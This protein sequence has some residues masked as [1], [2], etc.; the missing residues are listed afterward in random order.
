M[1]SRKQQRTTGFVANRVAEILENSTIDQWR[2]VEG[3]LNLVD[4]GSRGMT[5]EALKESGWL[6]EPV[7]LSMTEVAWPKVPE[8]LQFSVQ[9]EPEPFMEAVVMEPPFQ[10]ERFSSFKKMIRVLSY[11]L[12]WKENNSGGNLTV[13]ELNAAELAILKHCPK[14]NFHDA[15]EKISKGQ[16]LSASD[17]LNKLLP[18]LDKKGIA[19]NTRQTAAFKVKL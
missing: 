14:E 13:D 12:R 18:F 5:V 17:Q 4:I 3:K 16:P 8:K 9:E 7:W 19:A 6:R 1:A 2:H 15:Y 11:C 10:W